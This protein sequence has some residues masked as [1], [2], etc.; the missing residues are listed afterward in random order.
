[1]SSKGAARRAVIIRLCQSW[2]QAHGS[3]VVVDVGAD[4]GHVAAAIGAIAT[5]RAPGRIGRPDVPWV[6]ADGL[7]PFRRVDLA[8]I[9]GMGALTIAGILERGPKPA[10]AVLHAPDDPPVLR[11]W[12]AAHGWRIEAEALAPEARRYAEVL[13]VVP[14]EEQATGLWLTFGPRLLEGGDPHLRAHLQQL[15][16]WHARLAR[17]T[18]GTAPEK[19]AWF[20]ERS[21][22]LAARLTERGWPVPKS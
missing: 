1:M 2:Q 6:I 19:A 9:A 11:A 14:G 22:F 17:D 18:A 12:L 21:T 5:E 7:R 10:A 3:G 4:H 8:V 16:G 15:W 20:A 13:R